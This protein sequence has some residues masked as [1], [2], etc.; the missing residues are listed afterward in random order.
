M[1]A[2]ICTIHYVYEL[3]FSI[4]RCKQTWVEHLLS[5]H[6]VEDNHNQFI[7]SQLAFSALLLMS[8]SVKLCR[9]ACPFIS[10]VCGLLVWCLLVGKTACV[11]TSL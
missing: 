5:N 2:C 11:H 1:G 3:V 9:Q 10:V 4:I 6:A 7:G 8:H